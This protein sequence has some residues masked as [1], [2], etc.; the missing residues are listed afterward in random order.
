[1]ANPFGADVLEQ[2]LHVRSESADIREWEALS[3]MDPP[4]LILFVI[5]VVAAVVAWRRAWYPI[6]AVLAALAAGGVFAIRLLP[7]AALAGLAVLA[8]GLAGLPGPGRWLAERHRFAAAAAVAFA[9]TLGVVAIADAHVGRP[10]APVRAVAALP[11][12]CRLF[13]SAAAG[14]LVI[15]RRPDVPVSL[16]TRNDLYGAD[17]LR[18]HLAVE[19]AA[20]DGPVAMAA[21][22]ATCVLIPPDSPLA[23]QMRA[24]VGWREVVREP[25]GALFLPRGAASAGG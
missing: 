3:L 15:L 18:A 7:V 12:G 25:D 13:N 10:E 14:G 5:A 9:L 6:A 24:D 16:D 22:G 23:A 4:Q 21:L 19:N 2:A 20:T 17:A 8:A 11:A 1:V